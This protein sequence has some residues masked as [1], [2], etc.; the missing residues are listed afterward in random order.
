MSNRYFYNVTAQWVTF[1][2]LVVAGLAFWQLAVRDEGEI[3]SD[4]ARRIDDEQLAL[5]RMQV[6][7]SDIDGIYDHYQANTEEVQYFQ[8]HFLRQKAL[9]V[10]RISAFLE[11]VAR[12]H[13]VSLEEV[14]YSSGP[15]RGRDLEMYTMDLPL[16]GRY[17]DIRLFIG[18]IEASDMFLVI[19]KLTLEDVSG[20][21][22]AVRVQLSLATFFEGR[23]V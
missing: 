17:R 1:A 8:E 19:S 5:R 4:S 12:E 23:G 13:G 20:R 16:T 22:G 18:D 6:Q 14:R 11:E 3:Q 7:I 2:V 15:S 10:R 9:R 21:E